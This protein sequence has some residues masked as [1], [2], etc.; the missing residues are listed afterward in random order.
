MKKLYTILIILFLIFSFHYLYAQQQYL[1]M[2]NS[3]NDIVESELVKKGDNFHTSIRPYRISEV[4][5]IVNVDSVYGKID[6]RYKTQDTRHLEF[7]NYGLN[8]NTHKG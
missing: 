1:P 3:I 2:N 6:T 5:K 4:N 7:L 8:Y